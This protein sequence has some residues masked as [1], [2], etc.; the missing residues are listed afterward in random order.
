MLHDY[1]NGKHI[2]GT[3]FDWF[4]KRD[5][6]NEETRNFLLRCWGPLI[7]PETIKKGKSKN[8]KNN[9]KCLETKSVAK[10]FKVCFWKWTDP[11]EVTSELYPKAESKVLPIVHKAF[12]TLNKRGY[13]DSAIYK[14][15]S[16][17]KRGRNYHYY[18]KKVKCYRGNLNPLYDL[19]LEKEDDIFSEEEKEV[20]ENNL[21]YV[22]KQVYTSDLPFLVS[23]RMALFAHFYNNIKYSAKNKTKKFRK[24]LLGK[25]QDILFP[26][27]KII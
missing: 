26:N 24:E 9:W 23:V 5:L 22:R 18:P 25:L 2:K 14:K 4:S 6:Q 3:P 1:Q 21:D 27:L 20:L 17:R 16:F 19:I 11:K 8:T 15:L 13:L 7:K 12:K 10:V